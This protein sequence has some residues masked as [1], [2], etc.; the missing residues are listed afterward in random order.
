[1]PRS[2]SRPTLPI[3]TKGAAGTVD[4]VFDRS[5]RVYDAVYS[6]KDYAVEAARI[7]EEV[8]RRN[9]RARSLLDVACGTGKHLEHLG[10]HFDV[11]GIDLDRDLLEIARARLPGVR[12][13]QADMTSFDLDRSFDAVTC[14]FSAIGYALTLDRM[15]AAVSTM[16]RHLE[17]GGVLIV[18]P[19]LAPEA[20]E[21]GHI[22][23]LIV[24]Q[25]ELKVARFNTARRHGNVSELSF[26][27]LIAEPG[28]GIEHATEEHRL[29][30]F[31]SD[32]QRRAFEDAGLSVEHDPEGLIGRGLFVGTK[33]D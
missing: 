23:T 16:S 26:H 32:E 7:A 12:L 28:S 14:L 22:G 4:G 33:K 29:G 20:F 15:R 21:D 17:P 5:A 11:A 3:P 30:L 13:E 31:T 10:A 8:R 1:M 24:D 25:P 2:V 19:W 9:P 6:F 18:E 27:Y